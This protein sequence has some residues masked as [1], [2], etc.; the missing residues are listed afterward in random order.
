MNGNSEQLGFDFAPSPKPAL[1]ARRTDPE[2]S[3][4]AAMSVNTTE[5]EEKVWQLLKRYGAHGLTSEEIAEKLNLSLVTVS[6]R[7]RPLANKGRVKETGK[8]KNSSG[9][10]AIVWVAV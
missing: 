8:R 7:L 9:R 4:A 10:A 5:L 1:Q 6:P 2:T 3:R